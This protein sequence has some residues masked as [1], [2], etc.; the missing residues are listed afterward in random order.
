MKT[1]APAAEIDADVFY[2]TLLNRIVRTRNNYD[3]DISDAQQFLEKKCFSKSKF[4]E[5]ISRLA[6]LE[7][8]NSRVGKITTWLTNSQ[9]LPYEEAAKLDAITFAPLS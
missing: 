1:K 7:S 6:N 4:S 5:L 3:D 8:F 2:E 9:I